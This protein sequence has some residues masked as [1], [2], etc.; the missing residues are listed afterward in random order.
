[1][2]LLVLILIL[3]AAVG[4]WWHLS[5]VRELALRAAQRHCTEM[6]VQ[7]LDGSV[8]PDGVRFVRN[9]SGTLTLLQKFRFEFTTSGDKR[10][11]GRAELIGRRVIKMELEPHRIDTGAGEDINDQYH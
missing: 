9:R 2:E 7:F 6:G 1:M 10:Y 11:G 4:G 8:A 5:N 3:A